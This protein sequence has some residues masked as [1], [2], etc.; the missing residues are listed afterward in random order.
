MVVGLFY[1]LVG[2][3]A[4]AAPDNFYSSAAIFSPYNRHFLHDVGA[5]QVGLGA[6]L[7]LGAIWV[8]ALF[9]ATL[10]VLVGS[11][12]HFVS[13]LEDRALGGRRA[14]FVVLG[15]ICVLVGIAAALAPRGAVKT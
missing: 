3:W 15:L 11:L 5:F 13:H 14:D 6:A 7:L 8:E 10:A 12:L 1:V 4:F 9:A 2:L